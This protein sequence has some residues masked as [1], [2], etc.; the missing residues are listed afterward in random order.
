MPYQVITDS[1]EWTD[2]IQA[3][4]DGDPA[5]GTTFKVAP[6]GL[7]NRTRYLKNG[8]DAL[9]DTVLLGE[10]TFSG[11]ISNSQKA[12][13]VSTYQDTGFSLS[14]DTITLPGD[15]VYIVTISA[16]V[17]KSA[18]ANPQYIGLTV[19][20]FS[21]SAFTYR[22]SANAADLVRVNGSITRRLLSPA[23]IS[24]VATGTSGAPPTH[25]ISNGALT[26]SR[27][28]SL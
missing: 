17:E 26:I 16:E 20:G 15:G 19:S 6:Q 8:L 11:V 22:Y 12:T 18:T 23:G 4:A 3:P 10:Y 13:L 9:S 7:S 5:N 1:S 2:P 24:V 21:F 14:S 25:T 27:L 28:R